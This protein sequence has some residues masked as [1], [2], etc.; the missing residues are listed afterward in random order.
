MKNAIVSR[1][2]GGKYIAPTQDAKDAA[3]AAAASST[4]SR[5]SGANIALEPHVA[6]ISRA[7][8]FY[9]ALLSAQLYCMRS[10]A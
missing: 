5:V 7:N 4:S 1:A 10:H 8:E 2:E 9:T 6:N 3:A